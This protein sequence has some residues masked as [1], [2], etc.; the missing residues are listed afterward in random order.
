MRRAESERM[1]LLE[2]YGRSELTQKAFAAQEGVSVSTL[3]FWLRKAAKREP[4]VEASS[5]PRFL[6]IEVVA[7]PALKAQA[8]GEQMEAALQ[9]GIRLRFRVGTEPRYLAELVS[10]LG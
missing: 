6:P 5:V 9:S 4:K 7:S 1:K 3:Q 8:G 10:A 2:R